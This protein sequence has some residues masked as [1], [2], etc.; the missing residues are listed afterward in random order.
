MFIIINPP[1]MKIIPGVNTVN[2]SPK[3][4]SRQWKNNKSEIE[5][6]AVGLFKNVIGLVLV[7]STNKI[8]KKFSDYGIW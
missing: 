2:Y 6:G 8:V 1:N 3:S 4:Y 5:N 7:L